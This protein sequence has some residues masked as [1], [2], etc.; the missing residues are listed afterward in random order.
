MYWSDYYEGTM[1]APRQYGST[2]T[3]R[4]NIKH[5]TAVEEYPHLYGE[6]GDRLDTLHPDTKFYRR[7]LE[8]RAHAPA[9]LGK[10]LGDYYRN[11][12][13]GQVKK[14]ADGI[15]LKSERFQDNSINNDNPGPKYDVKDN[16]AN[17][18]FN[19]YS[20]YVA[21]AR[22]KDGLPK[23]I[24]EIPGPGAYD[25]VKQP[26]HSVS[27]SNFSKRAGRDDI[28]D[29]KQKW[30]SETPAPHDYNVHNSEKSLRRSVKLAKFN[31]STTN[32]TRQNQNPGPSKYR[33]Y[34]FE[35]KQNKLGGLI[36][37]GEVLTTDD[38]FVRKSSKEPAP[39]DYGN[40]ADK[41]RK[42][43]I[44]GFLPKSVG[45]SMETNKM[46]L[47]GPGAY[48]VV[49]PP[50]KRIQGG[51]F[52]KVAKFVDIKDNFNTPGPSAYN[53]VNSE[54]FQKKKLGAP[55][56]KLTETSDKAYN[57]T[58]SFH[59]PAPNQYILPNVK[60]TISAPMLTRLENFEDIRNRLQSN[61]P[62][63][64]DTRKSHLYLESI[65]SC[66]MGNP[67]IEVE[68][69][70]SKFPGPDKYRLN[71][72]ATGTFGGMAIR[73]GSKSY[74]I[75]YNAPAAR[76]RSRI[77]PITKDQGGGG[78]GVCRSDVAFG[79]RAHAFPKLPSYDKI[80][81]KRK[82][83]VSPGPGEYKIDWHTIDNKLKQFGKGIDKAKVAKARLS[84][85]KW[86]RK[87]L[88]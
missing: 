4:S 87:N 20:G 30:L 7:K 77:E 17:S 60:S 84:R 83:P 57:R 69:E 15:F 54:I 55:F 50:Q 25:T 38:M 42:R 81:M 32:I 53:N 29:V 19:R 18:G 8:I 24:M 66:K 71:P 35:E 34:N 76:I 41:S 5:L 62:L 13:E 63:Y 48:G 21:M 49:E 56:G 16:F 51:E 2:P 22:P 10:K 65:P 70:I 9:N 59:N 11:T 68:S 74:A 43:L 64:Y 61:E 27:T 45:N 46:D 79:N 44:G 80:I 72:F 58:D 33:P 86:R 85:W 67:S 75:R 31:K 37:K 28:V 47:P 3:L 23:H 78:P 73:L 82:K 36:N 40:M 12:I 52:L 26:F 6:K 14:R 39:H 88:F 1:L